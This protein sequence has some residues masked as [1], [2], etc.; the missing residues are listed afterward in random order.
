M[1][2]WCQAAVEHEH[3]SERQR[4][5]AGDLRQLLAVA[6]PLLECDDKAIPTI[7]ATFITP[8]ATS[9]TISIQQQPTQTR[10]W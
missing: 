10:P 4:G 6:P 5:D 8:T 1:Q 2:A 7:A 3:H 9:A